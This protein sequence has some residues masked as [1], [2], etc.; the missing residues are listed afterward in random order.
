MKDLTNNYFTKIIETDTYIKMIYCGSSTILFA[1]KK[2]SAPKVYNK[3][4]LTDIF[5]QQHI[6]IQFYSI[7]AKKQ[8]DHWLKFILIFITGL[9]VDYEVEILVTLF[10]DNEK[11]ILN[12]FILFLE[13]THVIEKDDYEINVDETLRIIHKNRLVYNCKIIN[14]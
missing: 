3:L 9:C 7:Q 2:N 4:T 1:L 12:A 13:S 8:E 11:E 10:D 14:N 5:T 6:N